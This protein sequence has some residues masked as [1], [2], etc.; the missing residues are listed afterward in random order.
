MASVQYG[1]MITSLKGR[2]GGQNYQSGLASDVLRNIA[3]RRKQY[4]SQQVSNY[5][6]N[7]RASLTY[8]AQLWR[9]LSLA[10][11]AAFAAVTASFPRNNKFG[12]PYVPSAYQLFVEMNLG[13]LSQGAAYSITPPV[14][15]SFP[16]TSWSLAANIGAS[17]IILTASTVFDSG[18]IGTVMSGS[19]YLSNGLGFNKSKCIMLAHHQFTAGS[20]TFNL[21]S[22]YQSQFLDPIAGTTIW[23][24]LRKYN[25]VT[26]EYSIGSSISVRL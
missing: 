20:A 4:N 3:P 26:G 7:N 14:V 16:S 15:S 24:Y 1:A 9:T 25:T 13:L 10:Q 2:V 6:K 23:L 8:V 11:Q 18:N 12:T 17:Q 19:Y 22:A 5:T 21:Y